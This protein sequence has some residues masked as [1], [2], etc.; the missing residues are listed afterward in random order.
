MQKSHSYDDFFLHEVKLQEHTR[1]LEDRTWIDDLRKC[2]C[3]G[4]A[5][6]SPDLGGTFSGVQVTSRQRVW[7]NFQSKSQDFQCRLFLVMTFLRQEIHEKMSS[8][9]ESM[10]EDVSWRFFPVFSS[11]STRHSLAIWCSSARCNLDS[12]HGNPSKGNSGVVECC[13]NEAWRGNVI[14]DISA[15]LAEEVAERVWSTSWDSSFIIIF[16]EGR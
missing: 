14:R 3:A 6:L 1:G 15:R 8:F 9:G 11:F 12:R 16:A 13:S 4:R 5:G 2:C 7:Q 10:R